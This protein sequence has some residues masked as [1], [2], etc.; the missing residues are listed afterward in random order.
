MKPRRSGQRGVKS[1]W[2]MDGEW[3][4]NR[5]PVKDFAHL[6]DFKNELLAV[7]YPRVSSETPS[8]EALTAVAATVRFK[9]RAILSTP[10]FFFAR[11]LS[12]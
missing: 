12:L 5:W 3:R 4:P 6:T 7:C 1:K 2:I 8:A 9:V 11:P 10:N